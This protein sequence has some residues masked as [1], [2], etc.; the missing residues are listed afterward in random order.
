[1]NSGN[2]NLKTTAVNDDMLTA[3]LKRRLEGGFSNCDYVR[4]RGD[5]G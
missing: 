4:K 2:D 3:T 1:M 5:A